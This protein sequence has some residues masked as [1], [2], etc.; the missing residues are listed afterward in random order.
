MEQAW[1]IIAPYVAMIGGSGVTGLVTFVVIRL[2]VSRII[3][4]NTKT[5]KDTFN[6]ESLSQQVAERFAG[7]TLNIDVTAIT[8][9]ALKRLAKELD[10]KIEKVAAQTN[11]LKG[12]LAAV[13]K[14]IAHLKALS[15]EER[16]ELASAI[17]AL[18]GEYKPPEPEE[19][20]TVVLQPIAIEEAEQAN[21]AAVNFGGLE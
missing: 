8:E 2:L 18:E 15:E 5:L 19:L 20:M 13:G 14:G 6:V 21:P 16:A 12:L 4:K 11:S 7:K 10:G 9:K 3:N 17:K 1:E